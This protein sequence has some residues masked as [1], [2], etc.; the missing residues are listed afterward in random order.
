M[1]VQYIKMAAPKS[2]YSVIRRESC[3]FIHIFFSTHQC[4]CSGRG[5][6]WQK[7]PGVTGKRV[8]H[9]DFGI[10]EIG[11]RGGGTIM[12]TICFSFIWGWGGGLTFIYAAVSGTFCSK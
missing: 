5:G 3:F 2:R 8:F 4:R 12:A 7:P 6:G 10:F 11:T 9:A 1:T